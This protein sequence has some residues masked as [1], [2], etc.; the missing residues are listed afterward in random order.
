MFKSARFKI[1]KTASTLIREVD[2]STFARL[3][4]QYRPAGGLVSSIDFSTKPL[5]GL[6][7]D[8][9]FV[10]PICFMYGRTLWLPTFQF[11]VGTKTLRSGCSSVIHELRDAFDEF[12]I[13]NWFVTPNLWIGGHRPVDLIDESDQFT[14][15]DDEEDN[16]DDPDY[17]KWIRMDTGND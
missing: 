2:D 9:G 7:T 11:W 8:N 5:L 17:L 12:E 15:I 4:N 6:T 14:I 3:L 16:L 10:A 1:A 13:V